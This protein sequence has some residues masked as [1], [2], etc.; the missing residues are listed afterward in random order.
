MKQTP[1]IFRIVQVDYLASLGL[2]LPLAFW[3]LSLVGRFFDPEAASWFG[4]IAAPA[5]LVGLGLI[6]WRAWTIRAV[7]SGGTQVPGVVSSLAFL[8]GR[9]RIRYVYTYRGKKYEGSN[10][11][12]A[13]RFVRALAPGRE[14]TVALDSARPQRAFVR[15]LYL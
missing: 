11:L 1:S 8:R 4:L 14:V 10:T 3:G 6:A 7:V 2:I 12:Q 9:G 5:T 15:E 13:N